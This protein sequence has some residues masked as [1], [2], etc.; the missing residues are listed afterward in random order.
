M[1][2]HFKTYTCLAATS[3]KEVKGNIMNLEKRMERLI[4]KIANSHKERMNAMMEPE[5]ISC[6]EDKGIVTLGYKMKEWEKNV[7]GEMH[8]GAIAAMFDLSMGL[9]SVAYNKSMQISTVEISVNY[10]RPLVE[11]EY[12]FES[13]MVHFGRKLIRVRGKA[14]SKATGKVVATGSATFIPLNKEY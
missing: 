4:D 13:E 14:L 9:T 11:E 2:L 12:L 3:G 7:R 10:I 6:D 1:H 5:L 8:G